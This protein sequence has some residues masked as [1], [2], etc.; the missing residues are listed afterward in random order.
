MAMRRILGVSAMATV[1]FAAV[2]SAAAA[3]T[4]P[5]SQRILMNGEMPGFN[6]HL[7]AKPVSD[8]V[9]FMKALGERGSMATR[10]AASLRADGFIAGIVQPM[11]PTSRKRQVQGVSYVFQLGSPG[12]AK[13]RVIREFNTG[14]TFAKQNKINFR[15]FTTGIPG[16]RGFAQQS[17]DF[18]SGVNILFADGPY[19]YLVGQ[20]AVTRK[21]IDGNAVI[22]A[23]KR[24]FRR[25]KG[26]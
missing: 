4:L 10:D 19:V 9:R 16:A 1:A 6:R 18:G 15:Q 23:A 7:T 14:R 22:T 17:P 12:L 20:G 5:L 21:A 3:P 26:H 11:L 13:A 8:E 2:T 25:V 24:L